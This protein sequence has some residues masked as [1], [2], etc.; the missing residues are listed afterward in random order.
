[1]AKRK[2]RHDQQSISANKM[3]NHI[4]NVFVR[5][6]SD[7]GAFTLIELLVVIAIIA[8]L[9]ALLLPALASAKE[10]AKR[11][12]CLSNLRQIGLAINLYAT[13]ADDYVVPGKAPAPP[14]VQ[15]CLSAPG[16]SAVKQLG[17]SLTNGPNIWTCP[18]RPALPVTAVNIPLPAYDPGGNQYLLGYQYFGASGGVVWQWTSSLGGNFQFHSPIRLG[19]A[20]PYW[21]LAA[22]VICNYNK[23][24]VWN[25][26]ADPYVANQNFMAYVPPHKNMNSGTGKPAGGN[27]VFCDG[28]AQWCAWESMSEFSDWGNSYLFWYQDTTDFEQ[29]LM[30]ALPKMSATLF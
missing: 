29:S 25:G 22:D 8:I 6:Q 5:K 4:H 20:K 19:N 11:A 2:A 28:S 23:S 9:A 26:Q 12:Q 30:D 1:V 21:A 14:M 17:L 7:K 16:A 10:R 27:E 15:L 3:K 13:S 24:S 18:D